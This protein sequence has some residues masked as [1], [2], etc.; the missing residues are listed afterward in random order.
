VSAKVANLFLRRIKMM[1]KR[2]RVSVVDE[3]SVNSF[4][5]YLKVVTILLSIIVL[6]KISTVR[7]FMVEVTKSLLYGDNILIPKK[8]YGLLQCKIY[9]FEN[10]NT[11]KRPK[12]ETK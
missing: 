11:K 7:H 3:V 1:Y 4:R 8:H 12:N 6:S 9:S 5:V 2:I 10:R